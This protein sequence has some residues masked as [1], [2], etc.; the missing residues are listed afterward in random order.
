MSVEAAVADTFRTAWGLVVA[1]LI[2]TTG[3][4]DLAEECAQDAFAQ[5]L[6]TW[7][8]D[9][10]PATPAAWVITTARNRAVDRL[11]RRSVESAKLR[12]I[13]L[14]LDEA[15]DDEHAEPGGIEDDRLRLIFTCCHPALPLGSRVALTLRTLTGLTTAEIARACLVSEQT[16]AKRLVRG[17]EKIRQ[18]GIPYQVPSAQRLPERLPGVL[19]VLYLLFN[20]GYTA[21][22]GVDLV[23]PDLC[24]E[25]I[26]LT[27]LLAE[28]MPRQP[29]VLGLNAL[30]LLH[31]ARRDTRVDEAGDVIALADQDRS[32]WRRDEIEE[33]IALLESVLDVGDVG[34]YQ[35]Q[36]LIA[37]YHAEAPSEAETDWAA[38]ARLYARLEA[39]T[40]SPVV[41][42]NRAVAVAMSEGPAAGLALVDE[43]DRNRALA[44]YHLLPAV[45][46]DLLRRLGDWPEAARAYRR[47][48]ELAT[49]EPERN[50]LA[51]RLAEVAHAAQ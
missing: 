21:T 14:D 1:T 31:H 23:R 25:A 36:A 24:V 17:K 12:E 44:G 27:R 34:P 10:V 7:P 35:L 11:R 20:E 18:A 8:K 38:I 4:W 33:G 46:A 19:A 6:T 43:L 49:T 51:K 50:Y 41:T 13:A 47:A 22:T 26:R 29:E 9:G 15:H 37:A 28:L 48:H 32:R 3:D 45:R 5:A 16:M 39:T 40:P 2:R 30:M 42:L